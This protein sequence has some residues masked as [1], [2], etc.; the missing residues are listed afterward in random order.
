MTKPSNLYLT[1]KVFAHFWS[2]CSLFDGALSLP[3]RQGKYYPWRP[4]SPK[5]GRH[6]ATLKYRV[7][8]P[9]LYFVHGYID[10]SRESKYPLSYS[11]YLVLT[12]LL[13]WVD[14]VTP[15][16]GVKGKIDELQADMHQREEEFAL[17]GPIPDT[18]RTVRKKPFYAA[19]VMIKGLE[20]RALLATFSDPLK[21]TVDMAA[22]PQRSNY[23][24]HSNLPT[25]PPTSIWHDLDD[26]TE[27]DWIPVNNPVLNLLPLVTCPHFTYFKRNTV[28]SES[29]PHTSKFGSEHSHI[30]LLGK[31]PCKFCNFSCYDLF[32]I[33][34]SCPTDPD[35]VGVSE[36]RR[37][38]EED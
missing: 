36:S 22:P 25:I 35:S 7:S 32:L 20:L 17:P 24:K 15:W 10:D 19:E 30:C 8:L 29:N 37:I 31:E 33:L 23:R 5:L 26:F 38:E 9:H 27:L 34:C 14:G 2:W 1:P 16:V 3:I 13:A 28:V 11:L 4:I 21:Q 18:T 6:L 12:I